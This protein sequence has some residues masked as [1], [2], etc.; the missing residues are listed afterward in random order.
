M[1]S[2]KKKKKPKKVKREKKKFRFLEIESALLWA[3]F[4]W[5]LYN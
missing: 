4:D 3:G 2:R 5:L 1:E